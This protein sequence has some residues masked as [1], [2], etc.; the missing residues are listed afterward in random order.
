MPSFGNRGHI[1]MIPYPASGHML[2]H[3]DLTHQL[4]LRG[5]TVT[6]MV[7]PKNLHYLNPLLSLHYS[8]NLQTLVLP[9]HPHSSIPLGV[10]N[11]QDMPISSVPDF[12][13]ALSELHD[14]LVQ[15]FQT[16][17]SPPIAIISDMLLC[18]WSPLLASHLK[19]PNYTNENLDII[20]KELTKHDRLWSVGPLLPIKS[21]SIGRGGPSSIRQ[22]QVIAWL[23]SCQVDK[24]VVYVGSGTQITLT[25]QQ[26][27]AVASA[28]EER[29]MKGVVGNEDDQNVVPPGFEDRVAG[30]ELVIKGW[31]PQFSI[32]GHR[33]VGSYLTHR[34]W[35]SALEGILAGVLLLAWPMQADHFLNTKMLV[36]G[37]GVGI[38][39]CEGL[40]TIPDTM[41]LARVL[42]DS[43]CMTR[44]E[45]VRAMKLRKTALDSIKEGGSSFKA[46][47]R[48]AEELSSPKY[49]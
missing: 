13:A 24:S 9:F 43:L 21:S 28:L 48:F 45:R 19:I 12:A 38:R 3:M 26:M 4:L 25:K 39:V 15:W 11:M 8:S 42:S 34:G 14:P 18:S 35:N 17:P 32:L 20:K 2:P 23:D 36:D 49:D 29:P 41:K 46:F 6:I 30:R 47:D 7:T 40:E 33:T 44:P 5:L 27:K 10:E 16:H 31:A 22:E 1:L 37:L